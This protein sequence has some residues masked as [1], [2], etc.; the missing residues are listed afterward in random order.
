[1]FVKHLTCMDSFWYGKLVLVV[2]S[3]SET[4]QLYKLICLSWEYLK[5]KLHNDLFLQFYGSCYPTRHLKGLFLVIKAPLVMF[6]CQL[7][8]LYKSY[9]Q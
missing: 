7:Q 6:L 3:C 2:R 8:K 1:M 9:K 5:K 4:Q